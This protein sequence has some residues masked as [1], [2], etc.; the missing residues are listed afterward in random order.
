[1]ALSA[2]L[3]NSLLHLGNLTGECQGRGTFHGTRK[4]TT[5]LLSNV[6]S[7]AE[8]RKGSV[9][10][11]KLHASS[12]GLRFSDRRVARSSRTRRSS[13]RRRDGVAHAVLQEESFFAVLAS[14]FDSSLSPPPNFQDN[15]SVPAGDIELNNTTVKEIVE[16]LQDAPFLQYMYSVNQEGKPARQRLSE[17][18]FEKP[19]T[20]GPVRKSLLEAGPD[21]IIMV[22]RLDRSNPSECCLIEKSSEEIG[23]DLARSEHKDGSGNLE[24]YW[25][26]LVHGCKARCNKCYLLRTTRQ[27]SPSGFTTYFMLIRAECFGPSI[28]TQFRQASLV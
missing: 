7:A 24:D 18:F 16:N 23:A 14:T 13:D 11:S 1:M 19:D 4:S 9:S 3:E 26:L 10:C 5:L 17:Q 21:G 28:E 15:S 22:H 2:G 27:P 25:G 8:W 6:C 12:G 20:W